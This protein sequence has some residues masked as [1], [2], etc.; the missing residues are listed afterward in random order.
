VL[1]EGRDSSLKP[2]DR[3][4]AERLKEKFRARLES[5]GKRYSKEECAEL[6]N[7]I[8]RRLVISESQLQD[9]S[10]RYEKLEARS[11]DYA[12]KA[13][14][15]KQAIAQGSLLEAVWPSGESHATVLGTP[16]NLEKKGS[17]TI[18]ILRPRNGRAEPVRIPLGK[19]SVLR[20]IKQSIF[21]E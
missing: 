4:K 18:L 17:E 20:R 8:E 11:L 9:I 1:A 14:I 10:I 3:E 6:L 12:G 13:A 5:D 7:R 21:G 15:A 16:E 19:I 2:Y